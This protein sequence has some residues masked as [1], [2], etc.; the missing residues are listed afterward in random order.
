[1]AT[2]EYKRKP[3]EEPEEKEVEK[4]EYDELAESKAQVV[5][6][7]RLEQAVTDYRKKFD[8]DWMVRTLYVRGYQFARYNRGTGTIVFSTRTGVRIPVNLV[9]AHLRGVRNQVTSFQPKWEVLPNLTTDSAEQNARYSGK[10]L[11]HVYKQ[12]QIKRKIKEIVNDALIKSIGIWRF[13]SNKKKD[14]VISV[15]DPFD[16]FVDPNIKGPDLNDPEYGAEYIILTHQLPLEAV[17]KNPHYKNTEGLRADNMVASAEYKR[18]LMQVTKHR[19][20]TQVEDNKTV[21]LK[22]MWYRERQENGGFKIRIITYVDSSDIPLRNE[23]TDE[24]EYPFE[25]YQGDIVNGELYGESW[26][27]HLIPIN[28]VINALESH[29][30][31]YNHFFAKGRFVMDKNSGALSISQLVLPWC[32]QAM[33]QSE[34]EPH[35]LPQ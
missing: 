32:R 25:I 11:D 34:L 18:F 9:H 12:A 10:V 19:Y 27:K 3:K 35:C 22:E 23:L 14:I 33:S 26:I 16:F 1:M 2:K 15:V 8:W 30:F 6:C 24:T 13:D 5:K 7:K 20:E 31:E 21:I 4:T 28:R 29:I 17:M